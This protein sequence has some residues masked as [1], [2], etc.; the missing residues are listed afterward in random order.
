MCV[1]LGEWSWFVLFE[2]VIPH[3]LAIVLIGGVKIPK[4][5]V[6]LPYLLYF[7]CSPTPE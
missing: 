1:L 5:L 4:E 7:P 6:M 3:I 2:W